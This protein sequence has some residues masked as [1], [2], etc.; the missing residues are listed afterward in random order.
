MTEPKAPS[1]ITR[2]GTVI[3]P[4]HDQ[5]EAVTFYTETLGFEIRLDTEFRPGDRW[6]EVAPP[7]AATTIALVPIR[8]GEPNT[9]IV[10][11][12]TGDADADHAV[13]RTND[14]DVD[15]AVIRMG[16]Y[17]PPMFT[18]RDADGN[19]FRVVERP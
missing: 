16:E 14:V 6:V 2:V 5:A 7:G 11:F 9:I 10:S 1:A 18:Y 3:I 17:V 19:Q 15:D 13:L 12:A 8:E 4:V